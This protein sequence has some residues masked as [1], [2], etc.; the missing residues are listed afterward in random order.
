M[1]PLDQQTFDLFTRIVPGIAV[2]TAVVVLLINAFIHRNTPRVGGK[3][4][5]RIREAPEPELPEGFSRV[6]CRAITNFDAAADAENF[7]SL[8]AY[9]RD[10]VTPRQGRVLVYRV[11]ACNTRIEVP[12]EEPDYPRLTPI[13]ML[14]LLRELPDPRL[15]YRLHL[16]DGP[17]FLDP[18][19]R[20]ITGHDI[21]SV[22]N[23]NLTGAIVLYRPDRRLGRELGLTL[24]HEWLHLVAFNS[25]RPIRRFKRADAVETLPPLAYEP[26]S[27][28]DRRTRV[29]EA[30]C[31]LGEKVLGYDEAVARQAALAS[32]VHTV[33]LWRHIE[34][35]LRKVPRRLASTRLDEFRVR[36]AFIRTEVAPKA[37]AARNS[38]RWWRRLLS[39]R[40][41]RG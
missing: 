24:L 26:V 27:F 11:V 8:K 23:A 38:R 35:I 21:R 20:K 33:V 15:V 36:A 30:W 1:D 22:G 34:K 41:A 2:A 25:A 9:R 31:E 28:G 16:A 29:Y 10:G 19:L 14:A 17:S 18:W 40:Q 39:S 3:I 13:E 32:P 5:P 6:V 4:G 12:A 7:P 37:Q